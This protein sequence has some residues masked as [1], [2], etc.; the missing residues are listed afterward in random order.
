[1]ETT[2]VFVELFISEMA[3]CLFFKDIHG[4]LLG[5]T[6]IRLSPLHQLLK[7]FLVLVLKHEDL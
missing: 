3:F 6:I 5:N 7:E 2:L 4:E 1:M